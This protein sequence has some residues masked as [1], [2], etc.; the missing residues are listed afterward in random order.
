MALREFH[1]DIAVDSDVLGMASVSRKA[2]GDYIATW[3]P[4]AASTFHDRASAAK[5]LRDLADALELSTITTTVDREALRD[6]GT[7][8]L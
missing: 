4:S 7:P 3:H 2:D 1:A 6:Y 8:R 5:L